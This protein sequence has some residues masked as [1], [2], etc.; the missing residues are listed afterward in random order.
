MTQLIISTHISF[1][2]VADKECLPNQFKCNNNR[3]I[4]LVWVCDGEDDCQDKSDEPAN[5]ANRICPSNFFL[6]KSGRCIPMAWKCDGDPDCSDQEDESEACETI[7]ESSGKESKSKSPGHHPP[8]LLPHTSRW[9]ILSLISTLV[10]ISVIVAIIL[11]LI[12]RRR[13]FFLHQRM[14]NIEITN[15]MFGEFDGDVVTEMTPSNGPRSS[16]FTNPLVRIS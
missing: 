14:D 13:G 12:E 15:P 11:Q 6:C 10:I 7:S 2:F 3:C 8:T 5:C 9:W 4:L 16:N 1:S